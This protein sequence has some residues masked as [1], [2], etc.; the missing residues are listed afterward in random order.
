MPSR[1]R[2]GHCYIRRPPEASHSA[3][4]SPSHD[5]FRR[6]STTPV[7]QPL[8]DTWQRIRAEL[9]GAA[10]DAIYDIWLASI[11]AQA[12]E[13]DV[14]VLRAPEATQA[15]VSGRFEHLLQTCAAAV[16]G[17]GA[18]VSFL[19]NHPLPGARGAHPSPRVTA[20][21]AN[22]QFEFDPKLTF[23]Q[24]V[25]GDGNRLAHAASLAVAELPAQAY[26]P[27]FL[28]GPPGVGKTHLLHAIGNYASAHGGGLSVRYVTGETFTN[29]F[30]RALHSGDLD[31]FKALYRHNDLLLVDDVQFLERKARTE[32][33]F[34]HTFNALYE[35]GSQLVL[36]SDRRPQNLQALE[37]RLRERF[38]SGLVSDVHPP[39]FS[40]RL[41]I[42]RKR[43]RH[44]GIELAHDEAL[45]VIAAR[46]T[47]NVRALEGALI[48]VVAFHS[49]TRRPIDTA[50]A[51]EVLDGLYPNVQPERRSVREIQQATCEHFEIELGDL[52]SSSRATRVTW[53]RQVA[54]YLA[55]ELT[56][57]TLPA[58]G[59]GF[60]GRNHTTVLHACRRT[61]ERLSKDR[62]ALEVVNAL[63]QQLQPSRADRHD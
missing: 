18:T 46:I 33:E 1:T 19:P 44:D 42:L 63:T 6:R 35:S 51:V 62:E 13:G 54:M 14:L 32:E 23:S 59:R 49:L 3:L 45:E 50:L 56:D 20:A 55:R 24:F 22:R 16:I 60:G 43:V 37:D 48:R 15:W 25:I 4:A 52:L 2:P 41:T 5:P 11:D 39:D 29:E 12:L 40:T 26:N 21:S 58:I 27:L 30:L 47:A 34:F 28:Y 57:E 8:A 53:P 10:G 38:E 7:Q 36:T 31:R 9:R 61:T 17:P